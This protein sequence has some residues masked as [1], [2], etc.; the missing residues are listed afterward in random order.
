MKPARNEVK[1]HTDTLLK[2]SSQEIIEYNFC[3]SLVQTREGAVMATADSTATCDEEKG[4]ADNCA[5]HV[6]EVE[7]LGNRPLKEAFQEF[8][9]FQSGGEIARVTLDSLDTC[10]KEKVRAD[11]CIPSVSVDYSSH[12]E[13]G[14]HDCQKK[15]SHVNHG[16]RISKNFTFELKGVAE[17][18]IER[19]DMANSRVRS[20]AFR[21]GIEHQLE[22]KKPGNTLQYA[23]EKQNSPGLR[24]SR[25]RHISSCEIE[26]GEISDFD[27]S[28]VTDPS[29]EHQSVL[30]QPVTDLVTEQQSVLEQSA[31]DEQLGEQILSI[32]MS[33]ELPKHLP[34]IEAGEVCDDECF[35][36]SRKCAPTYLD[37]FPLH[38]ENMG[39]AVRLMATKGISELNLEFD[40]PSF[41]IHHDA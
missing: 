38:M 16:R 11:C 4:R 32:E 14:L 33:I 3:L 6:C 12:T 18:G 28:S 17:E 22:A 1:D 23:E 41:D 29:S 37:L 31:E 9:D 8:S 19:V 2:D 26:E 30:E 35:D 5:P 40:L 20:N 13:E 27:N 36:D 21:C 7:G 15:L 24:I 25:K 39:K 10:D 34:G